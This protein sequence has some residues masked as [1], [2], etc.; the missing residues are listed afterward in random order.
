MEDPIE[1]A[2]NY[3]NGD[4]PKTPF[5]VAFDSANDLRSLRNAF[6]SFG[7][8]RMSDF[9]DR[10]IPDALPDLDAV[11]NWMT[12]AARGKHVLL[13]VGE[14]VALTGD[15]DFLQRIYGIS[16]EL[17]RVV[18]P[19]W[20]G[21]DFLNDA[22]RADPRV[23]Q[24]R[25]A[26]FGET[27]EHWTVR[28]FKPGFGIVLDAQNLTDILKKLEDGYEGCLEAVTRVVP[29]DTDWCRRVD[30]AYAVYRARNP[31]SSVPEMMFTDQQWERFLDEYRAKDEENLASADS[32]LN[33]LERGTDNPYL[34]F[35]LSR[36]ERFAD[37]GRNL[38]GALL[39]MSPGD[40]RFKSFYAQRKKIIEKLPVGAMAEFIADSRIKANPAERIRYLTD[41]TLIEKIEILKLV[42]EMG[43]VTP[44]LESIYPALWNYWR[45]FTFSGNGF[46]SVLSEYI[47]GYKRQ[48]VLG[49][50]E[51]QFMDAVRGMSRNRRQFELPTRESVLEDIKKDRAALFW[52]DALGCEYLGFILSEAE[53]LGL[54]IKVTPARAMLPTLTTV[55]RGFYDN[56]QG[57]KQQEVK[58]DKIKHGEF[59]GAVSV[60]GGV[61]AHLPHE[62]TV[63][64]EA[65]SRISTRLHR[66]PGS[67]VVL[68]SDH[69]A[70]RLAV[71]SGAETLWEMPEKGK[72]SGRCCLKS[73]FDGDLP[74]CV[75]ESDDERWHVLAGYDRFKGGRQGSVEVH[76]GA[77]IEE[78]VVPVIELELLD[79][80]LRI[81]LTKDEFKVTF[82]DAEL[83]LPF[84]CSASLEAPAVEFAGKRFRAEH[85][86][87]GQQGH[88]VTK[89]PKP[90]AGKHCVFVYDG[91]TKVG[92][93][94]FVVTSGGA[95]IND[96]DNFF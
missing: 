73:E 37:W 19:V 80:S 45:D 36:T 65:M 69:G 47:K 53:R 85:A 92:A 91:D 74:D 52:L 95:T 33:L 44:D 84:F 20:K 18:V 61:A 11:V 77:T 60:A 35:V 24:R 48:K 40:L 4:S 31:Q 25:C 51:P 72:H 88:W 70:T 68:T 7:T 41:A 89:L 81:R 29:L 59:D 62:L 10:S 46:E 8:K 87:N 83:E 54:K 14:Y 93:V 96:T 63:V 28:V 43:S 5:L 94:E 86:A 16:L 30:N 71:I 75:T 38:L 17:A 9:C 13:G 22:I 76:G 57:E 2:R 34:E 58:L 15:R 90:S 42:A 56:W 27:G 26:L 39:D 64:G 50:I 67:K 12:N 23:R 66:N 55:N 3:L 6:Q 79:P 21:H 49:R 1:A 32:L 82:R 78:M